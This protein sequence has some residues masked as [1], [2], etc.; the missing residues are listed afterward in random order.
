MLLRLVDRDVDRFRQAEMKDI[1]Q[2]WMSEHVLRVAFDDLD[3]IWN[4]LLT[5]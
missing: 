5:E 4:Q 2:M 3:W 1:L